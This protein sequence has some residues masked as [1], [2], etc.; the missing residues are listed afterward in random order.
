MLTFILASILVIYITNASDIDTGEIQALNF[1]LVGD[2]GKGG[3]SG[4]ISNQISDNDEVN[5][6]DDNN[7][8]IKNH[9]LAQGDTQRKTS[10]QRGG[11]IRALKQSTN[12]AAIAKAMGS[13]SD[14][15]K[16]SFIIALG[17]NFYSNGVSSSTDSYWDYLWV[18]VYLDYYPSLRVSW[19]PVF[20]NHDYGYGAQGVQAQLDRTLIDEYWSFPATNYSKTFDIPQGGTVTVVFIDTTILA[21]SENKCCNSNG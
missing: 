13:Y 12:Q 6:D 11:D 21:P 3:N 5:G 17:D 1:L 9:Q 15:F 18:N 20:G 14:S 8:K 7:S 10:I 2:W 16:P 19:Y 4:Y